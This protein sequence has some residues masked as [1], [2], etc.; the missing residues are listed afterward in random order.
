VFHTIHRWR[1]Q[2]QQMQV[3]GSEA[4]GLAEDGMRALLQLV[5]MQVRVKVLVQP[6]ASTHHICWCAVTEAAILGPLTLAVLR[7]SCRLLLRSSVYAR[8][9]QA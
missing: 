6:A 2:Q 3:A 4:S 5:R 9:P 8:I 1:E 7:I